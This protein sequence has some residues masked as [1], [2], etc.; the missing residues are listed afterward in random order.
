MKQVWI[1]GT[2]DT[3]LAEI[4]YVRD[5]LAAMGI[6]ALIVDVGIFPHTA[7]GDAG[8]IVRL[9]ELKP[10]IF[11]SIDDR[12]RA[13]SEMGILLEAYMKERADDI[14]GV[15][16][17]GGSGNTAIVTHGM[18][19][20][21]V[22]LPKIMVSTVA[23]GDVAPYVGAT[24][25]VMFPS[26]ADVQGLN[27]ITRKILGNAAHALGGMALHPVKPVAGQRELVG[28][29]MFGV[30]TPA[31]QKICELLPDKYEPLVFH[32]TGTG[33]RALEKLIDSRVVNYVIDITLTEIC[34]LFM[35]GVMSAGEDRLGAVIRTGVPYVGSLGALDM[36]NFAALPTV[37]EK[38][39]NRNLYVHNENVTLMRT[40][41]EEN[42]AM[43]V[44][45]AE[46]LN[47]CQG[48]V[49]FILPEG[50][51]SAIDKPGAPFFDPEADKALF[52]A[53]ENNVIQTEKRRL[54]RAPHHIN[55]NEFARIVVENFKE[56]AE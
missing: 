40:T 56:I 37:P 30:T 10:E 44:W 14:L 2:C 15:I 45:I 41:A 23:S 5:C 34:D 26:V 38:Y 36:V 49:R 6:K 7:P 32:A 17:L 33:G 52:A 9:A 50:G 1:V 39:K 20:L 24:D 42:R 16:G 18:R 3:K 35:G 55:D 28:L 11:A 25:I 27:V 8:E 46:R 53:I 51:V 43:G 12:G 4:L 13:V 29:S 54:I 48:P 22:G 19:A 47:Q 31:V 21:P